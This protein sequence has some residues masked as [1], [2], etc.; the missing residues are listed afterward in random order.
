MGKKSYQDYINQHVLDVNQWIRD[1]AKQN[2][3]LLLDLQPVISD[4]KGWR[5]KEYATKD[6]SHISEKGYEKLTEYATRVLE[7]Y[8][9]K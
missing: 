6:G 7:E 2:G 9:R 8:F 4:D 1:Y 5:K 3:L